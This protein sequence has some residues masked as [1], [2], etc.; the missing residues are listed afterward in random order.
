MPS[1]VQERVD[2]AAV[3][4]IS[5][6]LPLCA[7]AD[8][9]VGDTNAKYDATPP[10]TPKEKSPTSL[11]SIGTTD[12][13]KSNGEEILECPPPPKATRVP[14]TI[15][16]RTVLFKE[17]HDHVD[18]TNGLMVV[19]TVSYDKFLSA[20]K[21][22]VSFFNGLN[23][24]PTDKKYHNHNCDVQVKETSSEQ[25]SDI[26]EHDEEINEYDK[27]TTGEEAR[28]SK[29]NQKLNNLLKEATEAAEKAARSN[30]GKRNVDNG[31]KS[32]AGNK[33]RGCTNTV[34]HKRKTCSRKVTAIKGASK[35]IKA[36]ASRTRTLTQA[37]VPNPRAHAVKTQALSLAASTVQ[38]LKPLFEVND[39][40]FA[41]WWRDA[42]RKLEP[43]WF[44]AVITGYQTLKSTGKYGLIRFY[45]VCYDDDN[46]ETL[47]IIDACIFSEED[48]LLSMSGQKTSDNDPEWIGVK[49]IVDKKS[50]D[51]WAKNVGW[52]EVSIG[53]LQIIR[54][55]FIH[56]L[57]MYSAKVVSSRW[58]EI[59]FF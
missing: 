46:T 22:S 39:K 12:E 33:D 58:K 34:L 1:L 59:L 30:R 36:D 11:P 38:D 21:G 56:I 28:V 6:P 10:T 32:E 25:E 23:I 24:T 29:K 48:Y 27:V 57:F 2:R 43:M 14:M 16:N 45:N 26:K 50:N 31:G 37:Y 44:S 17:E 47:G 20:N 52:Y 7:Q 15:R 51:T 8:V 55:V 13:F 9:N 41:P 19:G 4:S 5:N 40:V 3:G 18:P 42:K 53:E 54:C 49:N 35:R